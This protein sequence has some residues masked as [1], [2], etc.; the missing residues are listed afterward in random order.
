M[1]NQRNRKWVFVTGADSGLGFALCEEFLSRGYSVFAGKFFE[2]SPALEQ[3][4]EE[5][6][7]DLMLIPVNVG[8]QASVQAAAAQ[9][10]ELTE[11]LHLI[12]NVAGI[13]S[14]G[15]DIRN[16]VDTKGNWDMF[17][18]NT[19]GPVYM[20]NAFLPLLEKGGK[21]MAFVSSEAGS[22]SVAHRKDMFGY[23]MSKAALNRAVRSYH[24]KLYPQGYKMFL[25]HPGWMKTLMMGEDHQGPLLPS[26]S[27]KVAAGYF[28]AEDVRED[29]LIIQDVEGGIWPF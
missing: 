9:V 26:E 4:K 15:L 23:C 24:T 20:V 6:E 10:G 27:A 1:E 17:Q 2:K 18:V 7:E 8:N 5:W 11:S 3:L 25:Y 13:A 16:G 21:R 22:I 19:L 29:C 14:A 12:V 28:L